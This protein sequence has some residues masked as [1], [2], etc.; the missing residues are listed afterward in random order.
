VNKK[1]FAPIL[2]L[3]VALLTLFV[4]VSAQTKTATAAVAPT[5]TATTLN[6]L[7]PSDVVAF[8]NIRA[9][10]DDA[11]PKVLADNPVKLAEINAQIDK[12]KT[13]TGIDV[14][15]F[16]NIAVGM[17]YQHPSANVTTADTVVIAH[18][19]FNAGALIAAGRIAATGKYREEKYQGATLYIF[20]LNNQ[21]NVEGLFS[22]KIKELAVTSPDANTLVMGEPVAVRATIDA[23][24]TPGHVNNDLVQLATRASGAVLGFSANVPQS[25]TSSTDFGN[26]EIT[27]I[28]G[29]IRQCYG[30]LSTTSNGFG[31]LVAARTETADQAR[32]LS[33]TLNALKQFGAM[34]IPQLPPDT[35]KIAQNALDSMKIGAAGNE[36]SLNLEVSQ[37][38]I[39]TLMRTLQ[40]KQKPPAVNPNEKFGDPR[41]PVVQPQPKQDSGNSGQKP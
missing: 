11:V 2:A 9:L 30:A 40:T 5:S 37:A 32:A 4:S 14:R 20:N 19:T 35:G 17:R 39:T 41:S 24:K 29:S 26:P 18:G 33:D 28:V 10:L 15:S 16:E 21:M 25:L 1:S 31:L 23:N 38:D 6:M 34:V 7:P 8:I 12:I 36:A 13:Q 3:A 27:K 22:M